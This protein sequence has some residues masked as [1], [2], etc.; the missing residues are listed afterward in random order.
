MNSKMLGLLAVGLLAG[1]ITAN[2]AL[3][4]DTGAP[5]DTRFNGTDY[6]AGQITLESSY[7]ITEIGHL[8][9]V[10]EG[11]TVTFTLS[12]DS[13][14]LPGAEIYSIVTD[15]SAGA[16][17]WVGPSGLDWVVS[18]GTYWVTIEERPGQTASGLLRR[19]LP[20]RPLAAEAAKFDG[21]NWSI[22]GGR[23][24]WR[25]YGDA[26]AATVQEQ[27]EVLAALVME[28]NIQAGI[29][30]AL[31]S[32]ISVTLAALDDSNEQNDGAALNSMYAFCNATEAQRGN[33]L[34]D[35]QARQL[36]VAANNIIAAIDEFAPQC[37]ERR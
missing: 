20:P 5:T 19:F 25:V 36:T 11:G 26:I 27:L 2:A 1:P 24:G 32:K 14:G 13:A 16:E 18:P 21:I 12:A 34:T 17:S 7:V 8:L 29:S 15:L 30:N 9:V 23:T 22:A 28:L 4:I 33:K 35:E 10:N 3:I 31:D 37:Q 6:R